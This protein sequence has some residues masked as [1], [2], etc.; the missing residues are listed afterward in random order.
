MTNKLEPDYRK[1]R[2]AFNHIFEKLR[3]ALDLEENE[4]RKSRTNRS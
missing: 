1:I 3:N 4:I 2:E